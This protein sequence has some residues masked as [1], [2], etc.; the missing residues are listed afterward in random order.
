M[1]VTTPGPGPAL[2]HEERPPPSSLTV[3]FQKKA[4]SWETHGGGGVNVVVRGAMVML[5]LGEVEVGGVV[6]VAMEIDDMIIEL[7][8]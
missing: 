1:L 8:H 6:N 5:A 7:L 2:N 4:V 3:S